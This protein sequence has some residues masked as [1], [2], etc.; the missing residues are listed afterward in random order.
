[1]KH[2]DGSIVRNA[3]TIDVEDY[4]HV[5]AFDSPSKRAHWHEFESRVAANTDRLLALFAEV[6]VRATFFVLGWVAERYPALVGRIADAGHEVASHGYF[7]QLVYELDPASFRED[8][9]RAR[10]AIESATGMPV[11]GY[12]APSF[13]ITKR[14]LWALDVL[15]EEGYQFDS[16]VFPIVRDRYGLPG[17]A[18]QVH[19]LSAAGGSIVEVPPSTVRIAGVTI[20][21]AGGGYFR[22]YPYDVTRRAIRRLNR[23]ETMPAVVYLHPWEL[24]PLQPR[25]QGSAL[26]RFRHYVNLESTES[27]LRR[28]LRDF[29]F[30][31]IGDLDLGHVVPSPVRP[32][33]LAAAPVRVS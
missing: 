4:Y 5:S 24:D 1:V 17:A 8:L 22:L 30:G 27:R 14:S 29:T 25:Q 18:R 6:Q 13:S 3:L 9:R 2:A 33:Q 12:R 19:R 31:P 7:H 15:V 26:S 21:V 28:L 23:R 20:P 32:S 16:S 11:R 10:T